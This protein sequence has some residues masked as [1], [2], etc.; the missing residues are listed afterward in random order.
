MLRK[1]IERFFGAEVSGYQTYRYY[2]E[3]YIA[4]VLD[5]HPSDNG[6]LRQKRRNDPRIAVG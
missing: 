6:N 2:K 1:N 4:A 3:K 5:L